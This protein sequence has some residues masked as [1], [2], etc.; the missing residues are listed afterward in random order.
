MTDMKDKLKLLKREREARARVRSGSVEETWARIE[1]EDGLTV[2]DK[3]EKLISLTG[4]RSAGRPAAAP[5]G[6]A[7]AVRAREPFEVFEN[8]Y[9]LRSRY[10]K[11]SIGE[12]LEVRSQAL[13]YLSKDEAFQ[14]LDLSS[15]L[16]FDL[17]TTG[18]AGGT[19]TV[20]FL[21]GMGYYRDDAFHVVQYFL[22]DLGE[23][24]RMLRDLGRFFKE[25]GFRSVV[26]YNGKAFDIPLLE[27]RFILHRERYALGELPHLDLLF[28][29]RSLWKHK[30]ESCRLFHLAQ[31]IVEAPR[32]EDIP[33]AEI[34]Y[35]YFEY[36][37]SG[38]WSLIEPI[39]YHNQEDILSLLG[40][41]IAA[42][43]LFAAGEA[44]VCVDVDASDLIGIGK[45]FESAK[46]IGRSIELFRKA[47][48]KGGLRS[49]LAVA[50]KT[51]L[52]SHFKRSADW[53]SAV[54][55]WQDISISG[56][57]P[58]AALRELSMYFEHRKKDFGEAK[59]AAEEGL[60]LAQAGPESLRRDFEKRLDRLNAKILKRSEEGRGAGS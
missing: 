8:R 34:P 14:A 24:E 35:R 30:H 36:L 31:Q 3:L 32:S 21:V 6:R 46:E 60:A 10:G 1:R 16:F 15:A 43:K 40:L 5:P 59:R 48:D 41:G 4:G 56:E 26:T 55:I 58:L 22:H 50:V 45:V 57:N 54:T 2:K 49:D 51:K 38:D 17:E 19:G 27:T 12:G 53:E 7:A 23:E 20:A 44:D 18:L 52:S 33:G 25:M 37:R 13:F 11:H 28:S 42:G 29:A 9:P 47:L 39:L